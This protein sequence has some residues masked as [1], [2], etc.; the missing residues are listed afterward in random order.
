VRRDYVNVDGGVS[1]RQSFSEYNP[2][3]ERY[4]SYAEHPAERYAGGRTY[5][6]AWNRA[7]FAPS[8]TERAGS[9]VVRDGDDIYVRLPF[10]ADGTGTSTGVSMGNRSAELFRGDTLVGSINF[11]TD[12]VP[13]ITVPAESA[14]YRLVASATRA[15][16]YTLSTAVTT[17]WTFTSGHTDS[18]VPLPLMSVRLHPALGPDNAARRDRILIVPLAVEHAPGSGA[19]TTVTAEVSHDDGRTWK[20]TPVTG[21]GDN[22]T[23]VV[24]HTAA[25]FAS[26]R[27]TATDTDGNTLTQTVV[28]AYRVE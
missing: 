26:W 10:F 7:V 3:D 12:G 15:A 22:R 16:P 24:R 20:R 5:R 2:D 9:S 6:V 27:V 25:G 17:T 4:L 8:V 19:V 23:A 21:T 13:P 18:S 11:N 28:R 14:S 1:W